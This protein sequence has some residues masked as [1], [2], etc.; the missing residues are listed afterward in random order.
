MTREEAKQLLPV[1]QAY[2]N[3]KTIQL[4]MDHKWSSVPFDEPLNFDDAPER[5]RVKP[6]PETIFYVEYKTMSGTGR[7]K[8]ANGQFKEYAEKFGRD[9][10]GA[11]FIRVVEFRE[12][13]N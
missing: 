9:R 3:G 1:I 6:E 4:N 11:D 2:A 8:V 7:C 10:F 13:I 12:V 5:Y